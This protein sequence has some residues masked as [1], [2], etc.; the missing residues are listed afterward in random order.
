MCRGSSRDT[1]VIVEQLGV[2]DGLALEGA[3]AAAADG[4]KV[5]NSGVGFAPALDTFEAFA[6]SLGDGTGHGLTC[7]LGEFGGQL[8]RFRVF[9]VQGHESSLVENCPPVFKLP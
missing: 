9:D 1:A 2:V 4:E 3:G 7:L 8:V 5:G 6:E